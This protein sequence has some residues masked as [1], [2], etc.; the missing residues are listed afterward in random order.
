MTIK[1]N[2]IRINILIIVLFISVVLTFFV[3]K[4]TTPREYSKLDYI[5]NGLLPFDNP[6]PISDFIF[7]SANGEEFTKDDLEGK[8][9]LM[10]FG[11][12]WDKAGCPNHA[13]LSLSCM[14]LVFFTPP[15]FSNVFPLFFS[16]SNLLM[17]N[18][19]QVVFKVKISST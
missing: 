6:I 12:I 15:L 9:T 4:I 10:Y 3:I 18:F 16:F 14:G 13:L 8:W 19:C 11:F 17:A 2:I 1:K 5:N 7:Y